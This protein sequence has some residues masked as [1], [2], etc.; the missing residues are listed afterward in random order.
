[1]S[2][3]LRIAV[4]DDEPDLREYFQKVLSRLGHCVVAVAGTGKELVAQCQ[5]THPDLVITDIKMPDLDGIEAAQAICREEAVPVILVSAHQDAQLLKRAEAD[6]IMGYLVK[7]VR[8]ADLVPA[9][10][11]ALHRFEQFQTLRQEAAGLR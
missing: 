3:A 7:P 5:A 10:A 1:M 11:Q 4:A 9:I 2:Q 8:Q 6:H